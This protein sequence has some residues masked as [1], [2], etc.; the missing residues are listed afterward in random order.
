[1]IRRTLFVGRW[2]IDFLFAK[3]HYDREEVLYELECLCASDEI[4]RQVD[5]IL[6]SGKDNTGF[7]Y[8]DPTFKLG[9]VVIGPVSSSDEFLDTVVH[10]IHHMAVAI[11]SEL[12]V[13]LEGE[14]PAYL[15]GDSARDLADVICLYGC[16]ECHKDKVF[17]LE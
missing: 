17:R 3:D 14:T 16:G 6:L 2:I 13:D 8:T 11:A 7:T 10:E 5:D 12:G 1:M 15:A 9:L 4:L